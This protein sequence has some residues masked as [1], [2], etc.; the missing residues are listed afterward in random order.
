MAR[1]DSGVFGYLRGR[2][3]SIVARMRY[4]EVYIAPKALKYKIKSEKLKFAQKVFGRRQSFN[5]QLRQNKKIQA[6]WKSVDAP[7]KNDNMKLMIRNKPFV[8]YEGILPGCGFTP[9]ND[10]KIIVK[11]FHFDG[12]YGVF[13]FKLERADSRKL[14]P[15]YE[16]FSILMLDRELED[17]KY[18]IIRH[19][20]LFGDA[21][22]LTFENEPQDSFQTFRCLH[23]GA[24]H[25]RMYRAEKAYI[26]IAA[27]KFNELKN[28]Y[29]WTDT[30]FQELHNYIPEDKQIKPGTRNYKSYD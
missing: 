22:S 8:A 3:G 16:V 20:S 1:F 13:D 14:E 7:G 6:F 30:Y 25:N 11:D 29:E 10:N 24:V 5:K 23:I 17:T 18:G 2:I 15:P 19:K 9:I 4:D 21:V 27:I 12:N 26:L 28:K